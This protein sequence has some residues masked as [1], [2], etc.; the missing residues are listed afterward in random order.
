MPSNEKK[1]E[2]NEI[3]RRRLRVRRRAALTQEEQ[4]RAEINR[5]VQRQLNSWTPRRITAWVLM[6][7]AFIVAGQHVLA[8]SGWRPIPVS[9]GWQDLLIGYPMAGLL[10]I[11][12]AMLLP[13]IPRKP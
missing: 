3:K 11:V 5:D 4:R 13:P 10:L 7:L 1:Q 2:R 9:M 6:L 12:G 8:H